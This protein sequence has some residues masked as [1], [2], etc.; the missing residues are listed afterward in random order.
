M[1]GLTEQKNALGMQLYLEKLDVHQD[2]AR[3][4]MRLPRLYG[5]AEVLDEAEALTAHPLC[6]GAIA[7]LRSIIG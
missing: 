7:G 5:G 4:L 1:R 6:R 3:R 2:V